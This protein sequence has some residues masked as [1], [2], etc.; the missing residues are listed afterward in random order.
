[1]LCSFGIHAPM[2]RV[3]GRMR[4]RSCV[5]R[6]AICGGHTRGTATPRF[7]NNYKSVKTG[8]VLERARLPPLVSCRAVCLYFWVLRV[9][10]KQQYFSTT[11][12]ILHMYTYY[13]RSLAH[14]LALQ[15]IHRLEFFCARPSGIIPSVSF[16]RSPRKCTQT[17]QHSLRSS[18]GGSETHPF[19]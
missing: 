15:F 17:P 10:Y 18:C 16:L 8:D 5:D 13:S 12:A 6:E 14:T 19:R 1:M 7:S 9:S 2:V 4:R 3:S 11:L